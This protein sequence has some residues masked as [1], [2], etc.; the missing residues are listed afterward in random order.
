MIET[1]SQLRQENN[2]S[3][4]NETDESEAWTKT[5]S[6]GLSSAMLQTKKI[7]FYLFDCNKQEPVNNLCLSSLHHWASMAKAGNRFMWVSV[8]GCSALQE[9][10]RYRN[11]KN[12]TKP[13]K[14]IFRPPDPLLAL[15]TS[16]DTAAE[17]PDHPQE[18]DSRELFLTVK[19]NLR[20]ARP[21]YCQAEQCQTKTCLQDS[22]PQEVLPRITS[23]STHQW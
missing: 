9:S 11:S 23:C 18:R 16:R 19:Q 20:P 8:P 5:P 22:V 2:C 12:T 17:P 13:V 4:E 3:S 6:G 14:A 21:V 10:N 1:T 7:S 15:L